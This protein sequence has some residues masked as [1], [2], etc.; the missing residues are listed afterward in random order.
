MRNI[1]LVVLLMASGAAQAASFDCAKAKTPQEKAIC[2]SPKLSA[3]DD[4]MATAY[5][6]VLGSVRPEVAGEIRETQR[7]WISQMA[8]RCPERQAMAG[9]RTSEIF[10]ETLLVEC[11]LN[12]E[13]QRTKELQQ[14]VQHI[15]GVTFVWRS[16]T[17]T[18]PDDAETA[19][20][21][22]NGKTYGTLQAS[23]PQA[24]SSAPEWLAWNKAIAAEAYRMA[25][26]DTDNST[27]HWD[28][29]MA[30]DMD[31]DLT[32]TINSISSKLV[33]STVSNIWYGHGA[34]HANLNFIQFNWLLKEQ[35]QLKEDDLFRAKSGWKEK[36]AQV[37]DQSARAQLGEMYADN[38]PAG[39]IP[40]AMYAVV[41]NPESWLLDAKGL[42]IAFEPYAV[43]CHA[44][45][46]GPV[47][48]SWADLKLF[49]QT[50]FVIPE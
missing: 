11:L 40:D 2:T 35:R 4:S 10:Q 32:V 24:S 8:L 33:S 16:V 21:M 36:L 12:Y 17:F 28:K 45:T 27:G 15:S 6:A 50:S 37:C 44:C 9:N 22:R 31:T 5:K 29:S 46:P 19:A 38:P 49:L 20:T 25:T 18:A 47:T 41:G 42:T 30:V 7:F 48:I 14:I 34:A 39:K 43:G 13:E 3:A 26:A 23:W 1:W